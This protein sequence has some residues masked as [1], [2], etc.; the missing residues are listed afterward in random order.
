MAVL[1][2]IRIAGFYLTTLP[3]LA[4]PVDSVRCPS[5]DH[6]DRFSKLSFG[7]SA[8]ARAMWEKFCF[9]SMATSL[10]DAGMVDRVAGG[11]GGHLL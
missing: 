10:T 6:T 5:A 3:S 8:T 7:G 11:Q 4:L 2:F 9:Q 1:S